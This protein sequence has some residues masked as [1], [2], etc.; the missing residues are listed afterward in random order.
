MGTP[1]KVQR[2]LLQL[3]SCQAE[4]SAGAGMSLPPSHDSLGTV[5]SFSIDNLPRIVD[6]NG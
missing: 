1:L 3:G 4:G 5:T 6:I 2:V